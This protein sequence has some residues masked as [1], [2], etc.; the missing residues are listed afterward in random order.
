MLIP[1]LSLIPKNPSASQHSA[2]KSAGSRKQTS[3]EKH[4]NLS[5]IKFNLGVSEKKRLRNL[6]E[7]QRLGVD[8]L[9]LPLKQNEFF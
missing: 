9:A 7:S 2:A 6:P 8:H 4:S 3:V 1:G 5:F